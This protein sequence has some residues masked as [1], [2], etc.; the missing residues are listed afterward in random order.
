[1]LRCGDKFYNRSTMGSLVPQQAHQFWSRRQKGT[2]KTNFRKTNSLKNSVLGPWKL[3]PTWCEFIKSGLPIGQSR[4]HVKNL[5]FRLLC[6]RFNFRQRTFNRGW[7]SS[8]GHRCNHGKKKKSH[9]FKI[10]ICCIVWCIFLSTDSSSSRKGFTRA[11]GTTWSVRQLRKCVI[12]T[13][14]LT[15]RPHANSN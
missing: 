2:K 4:W 6:C 10:Q 13:C 11:T 12:L 14:L 9:L 3:L 5:H 8:R 1:M 7:W 15:F